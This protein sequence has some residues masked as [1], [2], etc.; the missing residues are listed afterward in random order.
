M[1]NQAEFDETRFATT[2][3]PS[4]TAVTHRLSFFPKPEAI[5]ALPLQICPGSGDVDCGQKTGADRR[6]PRYLVRHFPSILVNL[7][8]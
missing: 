6:H 3:I 8:S 2:G 7:F 5:S 1:G 4:C